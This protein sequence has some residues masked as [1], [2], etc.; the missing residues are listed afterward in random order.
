MK[1]YSLIA[2]LSLPLT[3]LHASAPAP[4]EQA[5]ASAAATTQNSDSDYEINYDSGYDSSYGID[6]VAITDDEI[7]REVPN[8]PKII[9]IKSSN[10]LERYLKK[11]P[12][13]INATIGSEGETLCLRALKN[14]WSFEKISK[15]NPDLQKKGRHERDALY[16][17]TVSHYDS[18]DTMKALID[19][20]FN[21]DQTYPVPRMRFSCGCN[22]ALEKCTQTVPLEQKTLVYFIEKERDKAQEELKQTQKE[23]EEKEKQLTG[24]NVPLAP[25]NPDASPL[26][27]YA[28]EALNS[29]R[30]ELNKRDPNGE[31]FKKN[32]SELIDFSQKEIALWDRKKSFLE[33]AIQ[34]KKMSATLAAPSEQSSAEK[35]V[36]T[37]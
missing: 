35:V 32:L 3:Q 26:T 27:K 22:P 4:Q 20:G 9:Y 37:K 2:L 12:E 28:Y 21:P 34:K 18:L 25:L 36:A 1:I 7:E 29:V 24:R 19:R 16:Y 17:A 33:N 14:G 6:K 15:Y 23:L 11:H 30:T 31:R 10:H 5:S 8:R 13:K